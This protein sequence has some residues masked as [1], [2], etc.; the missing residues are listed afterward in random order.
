MNGGKIGGD[1]PSHARYAEYSSD[2]EEAKM[3]SLAN[4]FEIKSSERER[5]EKVTLRTGFIFDSLTKVVGKGLLNKTQ[6]TTGRGW[7]IEQAERFTDFSFSQCCEIAKISR[8]K[9]LLS[10]RA[11][12]N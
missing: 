11:H 10:A 4:I 3:T 2:I 5:E 7:P 9:R 8:F 12:S 6:T 1:L